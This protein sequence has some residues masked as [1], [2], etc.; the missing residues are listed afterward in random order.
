[1]SK[2]ALGLEALRRA[3]GYVRRGYVRQ[4]DEGPAAAGGEAAKPVDPAAS[5]IDLARRKQRA[6]HHA[7]LTARGTAHAA[8]LESADKEL[9][10]L[11]RLP[12]GLLQ[13]SPFLREHL[14]RHLL[15]FGD[16][17]DA[18][19]AGFLAALVKCA[20]D[21]LWGQT[22]MD[23]GCTLVLAYGAAATMHAEQNQYT[24]LGPLVAG[25]AD[26]AAAFFTSAD[27]EQRSKHG[28]MKTALR[29][30]YGAPTDR[31]SL[32]P[33]IEQ[34]LAQPGT[35]C[36]LLKCLTDC[37]INKERM[38]MLVELAS[39]VADEGAGLGI[40]S[41][42]NSA[43]AA[44]SA[45]AAAAS[46]ST[47]A[48]SGP[49]S[50][51]TN[52]SRVAKL[53]HPI[54]SALCAAGRVDKDCKH[55]ATC[56]K[57]LANSM[58]MRHLLADASV[59]QDTLDLVSEVQG[60]VQALQGASEELRRMLA[61]ASLQ[62]AALKADVMQRFAALAAQVAQGQ[63]ENRQAQAAMA[64]QAARNQ[65]EQRAAHAAHTAQSVHPQL[66]ELWDR[67][68]NARPT[69]SDELERGGGG[70]A[71]LC[72]EAPAAAADAQAEDQEQVPANHVPSRANRVPF[73][74]S[75]FNMT[76]ANPEFRR[77]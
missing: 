68:A 51:E 66:V 37:L 11:G 77:R 75:K 40:L 33:Y 12:L 5:L 32:L 36:T 34:A 50:F 2:G 55:L 58:G 21:G 8:A 29:L 49:T 54:Y 17:P 67:L 35:T 30:P 3:T 48:G 22:D 53:L 61:S 60:G 73:D 42:V 24:F 52:I 18:T 43:A 41:L 6:V 28:Q 44:S 25:L 62:Q 13:Q 59:S 38:K 46:T 23:F 16:A 57:K 71:P 26:A 27:E 76:Y 64:A 7:W 10:A 63:Q 20:V 39:R 74:P 15:L 72:L 4:Q 1:M 56:L 19:E 14:R 31:R 69:D 65:A 9:L 47:S 70:E 45:S